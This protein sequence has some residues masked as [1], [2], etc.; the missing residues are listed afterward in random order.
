MFLNRNL[1]VAAK[2]YSNKELPKSYPMINLRLRVW[3]LR[4]T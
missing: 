3:N 1:Y 2:L 4:V